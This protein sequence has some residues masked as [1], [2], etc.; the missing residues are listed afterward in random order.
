MEDKLANPKGFVLH[1]DG[2]IFELLLFASKRFRGTDQA[3][4]SVLVDEINENLGL[5]LSAI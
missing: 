5:A 3:S 1:V 2:F 4:D